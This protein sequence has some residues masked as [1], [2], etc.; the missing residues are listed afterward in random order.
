MTQARRIDA[1]QLENG[2][3]LSIYDDSKRMTGDRWLVAIIA[4]I[5]IP[6]NETILHG[7]AMP[8]RQ[9]ETIHNALGKQ[10][11]FEYKMKR[12][13]VDQKEKDAVALNLW[14]SYLKSNR[15]YLEHPNFGRNVIL[16]RYQAHTQTQ[17][18]KV[19]NTARQK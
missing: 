18:Y 3:E 10:V 7:D 5:A 9:I 1:I 2:L 6:I 19:I 12:N 17:S 13:F 16:K 8:D 14:Q 11:I 4:R 15:S